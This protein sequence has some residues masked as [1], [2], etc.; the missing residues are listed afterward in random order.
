MLFT[1]DDIVLVQP[2]MV[3]HRSLRPLLLQ[4]ECRSTSI[5]LE[6]GK[7]GNLNPE[8]FKRL[9]DK[10]HNFSWHIFQRS[11]AVQGW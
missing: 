6:S 1:D 4:L 3:L 8:I 7:F 11:S 9:A 2:S 10:M 5:E